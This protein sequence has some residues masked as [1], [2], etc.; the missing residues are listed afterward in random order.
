MNFVEIVHY[1][2]DTSPP[3]QQAANALAGC[4]GSVF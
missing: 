3:V 2:V 4:E 1:L